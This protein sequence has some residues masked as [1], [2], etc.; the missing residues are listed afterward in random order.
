MPPGSGKTWL[1][2]LICIFSFKHKNMIPIY[3]VV[4]DGLKKQVCLKT[5]GIEDVEILVHLPTEVN[6]IVTNNISNKCQPKLLFVFDEYY[7]A[8]R[9]TV[10]RVDI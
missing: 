4:N 8:L 10:M 1:N 9:N 6:D 2:I 7:H 3:I 5:S